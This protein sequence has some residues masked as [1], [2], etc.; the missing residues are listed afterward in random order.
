[1]ILSQH[2]KMYTHDI[3]VSLTD[4]L[5]IYFKKKNNL[6]VDHALEAL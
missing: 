3:R 5:E 6:V 2:Y 1:M 4:D